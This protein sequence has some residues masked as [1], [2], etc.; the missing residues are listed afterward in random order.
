MVRLTN[1]AYRKLR[2]F[3]IQLPLPECRVY[4]DI[5]APD[6]LLFT[7]SSDWAWGAH[8]GTSFFRSGAFSPADAAQHIT[9]KELKAIALALEILGPLLTVKNLAIFSDS[10]TAV[11]VLRKLYTKSPKLRKLLGRIIALTRAYGLSL[12]VHHIAGVAN[13]VADILSRTVYHN[14]F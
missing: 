5:S 14:T 4:W 8:V 9:Y 6:E 13:E 1:A 11:Q 2:D 10:S 7:D 3:W 12:Q